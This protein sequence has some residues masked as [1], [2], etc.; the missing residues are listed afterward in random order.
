[1][2]FALSALAI[3]AVVVFAVACRISLRR[4]FALVMAGRRPLSDGEFAA[5]FPGSEET[6]ADVRSRLAKAVP[7]DARLMRPSDRIAADLRV[8][9]LD[10]LDTNEIVA[11][12]E[13]RFSIRIPEA[14]ASEVRTVREL[15]E[16]VQSLRNG[17]IASGP[18]GAR[19]RSPHWSTGRH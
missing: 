15:V 6:A 17:K 11:G 13:R 16:L 3:A 14:R 1:M 19:I 2:K 8:G 10:G 18:T 9:A 5:L 7:G 4:R 12:L